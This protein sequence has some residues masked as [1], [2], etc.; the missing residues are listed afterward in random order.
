MFL[1]LNVRVRGEVLGLV[2]GQLEADVVETFGTWR[3]G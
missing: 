1:G 2:S 3:E